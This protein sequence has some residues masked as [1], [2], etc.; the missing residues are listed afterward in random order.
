MAKVDFSD[1]SGPVSNPSAGGVAPVHPIKHQ[2][3]DVLG[4]STITRQQVSVLVEVVQANRLIG[5][6]IAREVSL[7]IPL[8]IGFEQGYANLRAIAKSHTPA[9]AVM[10]RVREILASKMPH[11]VG[12]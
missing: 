8:N 10:Q 4:G 2:R 5:T 12:V 9:E 3:I 1:W 7:D 6:A 11:P